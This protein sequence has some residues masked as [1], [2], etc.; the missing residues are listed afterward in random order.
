LDTVSDAIMEPNIRRKIQ[1]YS[2]VL[3]LVA[4]IVPLVLAV[5]EYRSD[6][7]ACQLLYTRSVKKHDIVDAANNA[8]TALIDAEVREQNYVLTGET[9]YSEAY[10]EDIRTWQDESAAL[11]L[12]ARNDPAT[13]LVQDFSKA[14]TRTLGELALVFSLYEKSG[15]DAALD[16]IRKSSGIVYLDQ[17]RN[18]VARIKETDGGA[19][20]GS[21]Q[22]ITKAMSSLRR[23]AAGSVALFLVAATGMLLLFLE[24]RRV[25]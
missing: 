13:L 3:L 24:I 11:E 20:D 25:P 22:L 2:A 21:I 7:D 15:R 17:A 18:S 12:V 19:F 1:K 14:G 8:L 6:R 5:R 9:V 10:A 4:A 23:L 16:R